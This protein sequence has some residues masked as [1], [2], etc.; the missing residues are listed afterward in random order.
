MISALF[1]LK[2]GAFLSGVSQERSG[3]SA[4]VTHHMLGL[5]RINVKLVRYVIGFDENTLKKRSFSSARILVETCLTFFL[6]K[7][8]VFLSLGE[9]GCEVFVKE[10]CCGSSRYA[11]PSC[12]RSE[13][14]DSSWCLCA[15]DG[16]EI[17]GQKLKRHVELEHEQPTAQSNGH[18]PL[19]SRV[20][21]VDN[22]GDNGFGWCG[23][24]EI[25][26]YYLAVVIMKISLR[27][28]KRRV[29]VHPPLRVPE[30]QMR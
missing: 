23:V 14:E 10:L 5:L 19:G 6:S 8:A 15:R 9:T 28:R 26:M 16:M 17:K 4:M 20:L 25:V 3:W 24:N 22:D 11:A 1:L 29:N 27:T 18:G 13:R 30:E 2:S 21:H 7:G 12:L